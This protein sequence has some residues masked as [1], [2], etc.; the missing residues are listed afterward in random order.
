MRVCA[1]LE[2][3]GKNPHYPEPDSI[4]KLLRDLPPSVDD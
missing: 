2:R 3:P 1:V 4:A